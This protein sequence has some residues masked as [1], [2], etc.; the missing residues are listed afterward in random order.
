MQKKMTYVLAALAGL[1]IV[2]ILYCRAGFNKTFDFGRVAFGGRRMQAAIDRQFAG[3]G[4]DLRGCLDSQEQQDERQRIY[5][6]LCH[7]RLIP[8]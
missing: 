7:N 5:Y 4:R 8:L 1:M 2:A 6:S 3:A